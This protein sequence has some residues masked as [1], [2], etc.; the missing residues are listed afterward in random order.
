M[1]AGIGIANP[2]F[3]IGVVENCIDPRNEGRVQ[4]R[5]FSVHGTLEEIPTEHLPWAICMKGDYTPN[6]QMIPELNDFVFGV[7]LDGRDA[8]TPMIMGLIPTQFAEAPNP[9]KNGWG[10]KVGTHH[11]SEDRLANGSKPQNFGQPQQDRL[12]RGENIEETYVMEQSVAAIDVEKVAEGAV[13]WKEPQPAYA[14]Q[15]PFNKVWKTSEHVIELDDTKN[16]ERIMIW[17]KA[18]SYIQIDSNGSMTTRSTGDKFDVNKTGQHVYIGGQSNVTIMGH[19]YMYHDGNVTQEINGD[20]KQIIHGNHYVGVGG[21]GNF[22][23]SDS[24]QIKSNDMMLDAHNGTMGIYAKDTLNIQSKLDMNLKANKTWIDAAAD[25][26]V[27]ADNLYMTGESDANLYGAA[28]V[29]IGGGAEGQVSIS[30]ATVAIDDVVTMANG[31]ADSATGGEQGVGAAR[32]ELPE[33]PAKSTATTA[34][35]RTTEPVTSAGITSVD[36]GVIV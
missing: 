19:T 29:Q 3:F 15:Y 32:T 26:N 11:S 4:V 25:L 24:L 20:Y 34:D 21:Q 9:E 1:E 7:F 23:I 14:A 8:Q 36:E 16:N 10:T 33:P 18:G 17:H 35:K 31:E 12:A 2:L 28:N 13:A 5:A 6:G 22:N 30:A 27:W